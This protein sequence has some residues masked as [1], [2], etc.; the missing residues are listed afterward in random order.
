MNNFMSEA[1]PSGVL[2]VMNAEGTVHLMN[3]GQDIVLSKKD[4]SRLY[5]MAYPIVRLSE[6]CKTNEADIANEGG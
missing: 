1:L 5:G 6:K 3:L 4:I 2:A